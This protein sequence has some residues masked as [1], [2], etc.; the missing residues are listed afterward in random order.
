MLAIPS[1]TGPRRDRPV[2]A[3]RTLALTT[4]VLLAMVI[5]LAGC[6]KSTTTNSGAA[7]PTSSSSVAGASAATTCPTSNTTA[8]AKTKFVLHTGLAFGTFHRYIYKPFKAGGFS[9]GAHGRVVAFVKAGATALFIK[10]EIRLATEDVKA[11]PTLCKA[12]AAPLAKLGD[13]ISGAVTKLKGGDPSAITDANSQISD[14]TSKSSSNGAPIT[15]RTDE[16]AG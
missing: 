12:I 7:A 8:F 15:E 2:G 11:N 3:R 5:A 9:K 13:A 10:R 1:P 4:A 16:S 6:G 14:I